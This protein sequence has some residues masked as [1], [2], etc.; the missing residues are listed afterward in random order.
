MV[1]E[2]GKIVEKETIPAGTFLTGIRTDGENF[3]DVQV[4]DPSLVE[5]RE[6]GMPYFSLKEGFTPDPAAKTYRLWQKKKDG[7]RTVN[8]TGLGQY[9]VLDGIM[10]AG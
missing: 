10:Y 5:D 4:V 7:E 8:D 1:D 3:V 2:S 9:D 6:E